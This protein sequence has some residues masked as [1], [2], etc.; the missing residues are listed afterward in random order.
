MNKYKPNINKMKERIYI[1]RYE[2][3]KR[4]IQEKSKKL[5]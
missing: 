2:P 4:E 1:Y 3:K 5:I